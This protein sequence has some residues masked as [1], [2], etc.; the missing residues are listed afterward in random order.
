[1]LEADVFKNLVQ[2]R[3]VSQLKKAALNLL[4]RQAMIETGDE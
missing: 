1:M 3:G 4:V 2:Y